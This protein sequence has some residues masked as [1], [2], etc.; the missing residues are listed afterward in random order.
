MWD[1]ER[2]FRGGNETNAQGNAP[3]IS[4][5]P[6]QDETNPSVNLN[7]VT[8]GKSNELVLVRLQVR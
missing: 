5:G 7:H 1:L 8:L 4:N 6:S 2:L 3:L